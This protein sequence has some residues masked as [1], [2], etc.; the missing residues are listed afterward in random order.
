MQHY[1]ED[2][3]KK[4]EHYYE[5]I[6]NSAFLNMESIG[7]EVPFYIATHLPQNQNEAGREIN[8][9]IKKLDTQGIRVL[10]IN[11]FDLCLEIIQQEDELEDLFEEEKSSSKDEF[12]ETMQSILDV[13]TEVIPSVLKK[14]KRST[15][16][17][18]FITGVGEVFPFIRSHTILNNL[19]RI[20]KD[21]P[22]VLFFPGKYNGTSL[23][24]FNLLKDD[25]YYRAFNLDT[26][27][28][29]QAPI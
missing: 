18:L 9:L 15:Y 26:I 21:A 16:D 29:K 25:N 19:Q 12:L 2:L 20:A 5:Q 24:L 14:L 27:N 28:L 3:V 8:A 10:E 23:E 17:V 22:T 13:E 6:N 11:L 4:F 1:K 7:G